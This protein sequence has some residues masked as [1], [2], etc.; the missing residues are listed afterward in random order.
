MSVAFRKVFAA[1]ALLAFV[2]FTVPFAQAENY[3]SKPI[4][5][6]MPFAAGG[7]SDAVARVLAQRLTAQL[8]VQVL[9]ENRPGGSGI[10]GT[11]Q[12]ARA[13]PDGYT[14][15]FATT[16]A[17][18]AL[19]NLR[20]NLPYDPRRSFAPVSLV[21]SVPFFVIAHSSV[22]ARTLGEL[23]SYA[24][25]NPGVLNLGTPGLGTAHHLTFELFKLRTGVDIIH[26]P[27]VGSGKVVADLLAGRVQL[28]VD[29]AVVLLPH[30]KSGT[31]RALATASAT[32]NEA[33]PEVPT[34]LEAGVAGF[35]IFAWNGVVAPA[36]TPKE[37]ISRLHEE[38][39][40]ASLSSDMQQGLAKYSVDSITSK[41]PEDFAL[42]IDKEIKRYG[43][44]VRV[45]KL[46]IEE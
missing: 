34:A 38:I 11:A 40:K 28:T 42:H 22:P 43:E 25:A 21:S 29:N 9:V 32:R 36:N 17:F 2:G 3:P 10:P 26:V 13:E 7:P 33:L 24:K 6:I 1:L 16:A 30:I 45:A 4:K 20:K 41:S 31:L 5:I 23:I 35:E 44:L 14:L 18:A 12:G 8:G 27:Y 46:K 37:I 15:T 39:V 19:P